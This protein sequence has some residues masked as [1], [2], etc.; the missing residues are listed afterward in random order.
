MKPVSFEYFAPNSVQEALAIKNQYGDEVKPLAGGQS[1]IPAMNFRV[2]Q[3]TV[4][5]DLNGIQEMRFVNE[6]DGKLN[7]GAMTT[8]ASVGKNPLVKKFNPLIDEVIPNIAHS[9]IRNRGTFGGSLAHADPASELPVVVFTLGAKFKAESVDGSRWIEAEDFIETMFT[10]SLKENEILSE[11]KFPAFPE[12]TGWSFMEIARRHGDYAMAG[13]AGL[14]TLDESGTCVAAKIVYLNV[15]ERAIIAR[16][17]AKMMVGEK[18]TKKLIEE[19]AE[20]ATENEIM[21]FGNV[22]A[23]P[24]YQQ[25]LSKV[26][27]NRVLA[28]A[29]QRAMEIVGLKGESK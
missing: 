12:N 9:Q 28:K 24:E 20:Y 16:D 3:P 4:L 17:G 18:I 23:T 25:H 26:L 13:L 11:I 14:I 21:P 19:V 22:H 29:N 6:S 15:G 8:Q 7:I 10:I 5:L 27:T 1:L 2:I